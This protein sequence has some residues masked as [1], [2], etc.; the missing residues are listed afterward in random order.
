MNATTTEYTIKT[1]CG[2]DTITAA[3]IDEAK[4]EYGRRHHYDFDAVTEIPG[5]WYWIAVDGVRIED[6]TDD[7]PQW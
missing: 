3:S 4:E 5:S 2:L 7:M 6:E 1:E